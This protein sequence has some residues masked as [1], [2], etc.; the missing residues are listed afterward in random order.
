M[1]ATGDVGAAGTVA[2]DTGP[3]VDVDDVPVELVAVTE[4]V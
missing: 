4:N 3:A 1:V 2:G